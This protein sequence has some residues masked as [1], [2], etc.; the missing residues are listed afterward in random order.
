[1]VSEMGENVVQVAPVKA[2]DSITRMKEKKGLSGEDMVGLL[3][4]ISPSCRLI[5]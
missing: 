3:L 1:M 4:G 2:E 5:A